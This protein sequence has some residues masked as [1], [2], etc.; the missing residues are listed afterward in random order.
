MRV[1][2]RHDDRRGDLGAVD[3]GDTADPLAAAHD[4]VDRAL[5]AQRAASRFERGEQGG[6]H[7]AAAADRS[8]HRGHVTHRVR[9]RAESAAGHLGGDAPHHRSGQGGGSHDRFFVE[10]GPQHVGSAPP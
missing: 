1:A 10:V 6:G 9:Q 5:R 7:L 4:R 8:A 3:Q 2:G